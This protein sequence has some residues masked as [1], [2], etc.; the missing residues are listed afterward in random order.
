M[1]AQYINRGRAVKPNGSF[2][3]QAEG[4]DLVVSG[5]SQFHAR[6]TADVRARIQL[7]DELF[8]SGQAISIEENALDLVPFDAGEI[9]PE[10]YPP[11]R[12]EIGRNVETLRREV[13]E[14][15]VSA[16]FDLTVDSHA[17]IA[18]MVFEI[19]AEPLPP[20]FKA[21]MLVATDRGFGLWKRLNESDDTG[22]SAGDDRPAY[23]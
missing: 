12:A 4:L 19:V 18:V 17:P 15:L 10:P 20:D 1:E 14:S 6:R 11:A 8:R 7:G 2:A 9:D 21:Q 13:G 5:P 22:P 16:G 3:N 23:A